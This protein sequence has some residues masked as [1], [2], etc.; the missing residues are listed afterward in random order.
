MV[1]ILR[2][3]GTL[4]IAL[5][6]VPVLL[7]DFAAF[8]LGL[9]LLYGMASLGVGLAWG[10]AGFLPLGQ[11]LFFGAAAYLA[12]AVLLH[13]PGGFTAKLALL[14]LIPIAMSLLAF[15]AAWIIFLRQS[16][17]G[18]YFSLITLALAM[19]AEQVAGTATELTGGFNG[20]GGIPSLG[21]L[22][23]F[24]NYYYLIV[25]TVVVV[26]TLLLCFDR[27]PAGLLSRSIADNESRLRVFG[28]PT[29][30]LKAVIFG[31]SAF[32][33]G[34]A[35][36]LFSSHQGIVTPV[37]IGF[38]MS[39]QMV[40]WTAV[41]GCFHAL[42]PLLGAVAIGLLGAELRDR[43]ALWEVVIAL[44][45]IGVVV[46]LPGG[47]AGLISDLARHL[48][49]KS[50]PLPT[51]REG[52]FIPAPTPIVTFENRALEFD[53]VSADIGDVQILDRLSI[54]A[55][56]TGI[57]CLIGPNGAGK[58]SLINA[59]TG[60]L[61]VSAGTI[62][63]GDIRVDN[64]PAYQVL[65]KGMGRKFQIPSVF[66]ELTVEE[67]L[68]IAMFAGRLRLGDFFRSA[69]LRWQTPLLADLMADSRVPFPQ[70]KGSLQA[71]VI[72][73]GHRQ[74]LELVMATLAEPKILLLDEP[75]AGM[76]PEET[77]TT[78]SL[79]QDLQERLGALVLVVEHDMNLV[80]ALANH[81][82]VLHQ[83]RLLAEGS[84]E[85]VKVNPAVQAVYSGG[86]K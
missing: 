3:S 74:I 68:R 46:R 47:L 41:G 79:I 82:F 75:C 71:S 27:L 44:V 67:N 72:S 35:G 6:L 38:L 76:S 64:L 25:I 26:S 58:T 8:Q 62:T 16:E 49:P 29:H 33:A 54:K 59:M 2:T 7:G 84:L 42:G 40:I 56:E 1:S 83:G 37:S 32:P 77:K 50:D 5:L 39:A 43:I 31:F 65:S 60:E 4:L 55:G 18:P 63:V 36:V 73:Q 15:G 10:R 30:T 78:I 20:M 48:M 13:V 22:D 34:I 19:V 12:G 81:V 11:S 14:T 61:A 9:F 51:L 23:P 66:G 21:N 57:I 85:T 69:P 52:S 17:S 86:R 70:I 80:D 24:G 45:F 53:G 28:F